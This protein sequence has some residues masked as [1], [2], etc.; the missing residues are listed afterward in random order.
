MRPASTRQETSPGPQGKSPVRSPCDLKH[1]KAQVYKHRSTTL[2]AL[3]AAITQAVAVILQEMPQRTMDT[4]WERFRQCVTI[5]ECR[6]VDTIFNPINVNG[7]VF[8][9]HK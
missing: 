1:L 9:V 8:V 5:G 7:I 6:L 3:K 4:F 2:Q